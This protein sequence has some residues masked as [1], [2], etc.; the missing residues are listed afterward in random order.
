MP[1]IDALITHPNVK[2]MKSANW[3]L[4]KAIERKYP[5]EAFDCLY[6][7]LDSFDCLTKSQENADTAFISNITTPTAAQGSFSKRKLTTHNKEKGQEES[8]PFS[9]PMR[10]TSAG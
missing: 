1:I 10:E 4:I 7:G 2:G 6:S 8:C 5:N 3:E 9:S